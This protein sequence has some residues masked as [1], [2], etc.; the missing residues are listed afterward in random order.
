[1]TA[2]TSMVIDDESVAR[3]ILES[4]IGQLEGWSAPVPCRSALEAL[5]K[6]N[7]GMKPDVIF[8]DINMPVLSGIEFFR[9]LEEPPIAVFTTAYSEFAVDAFE[10]H[11]TDY[12]VKP[13]SFQRFLKTVQR[14]QSL[15]TP[16]KDLAISTT[17]KRDYM[18]VKHNGKMQRID[19]DDIIFIEAK[20]DY[21]YIETGQKHFMVLMPMKEIEE[22]VPA[23]TFRR[24]HRS[25]IV[26]IR[27][28]NSVHGNIIE[29]EG[30][31]IPIGVNYKEDFL[32][33][34]T[35]RNKE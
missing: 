25:F 20:G 34:I 11:V 9:L 27:K 18:F 26:N 15:L 22:Y 5:D 10:L 7:K 14:I 3:S 24:I 23:E 35:D 28:I 8:L 1:M 33:S 4:Y 30:K 32:K 6:I 21:I 19:L 31:E 13:I 17:I 29:M 2:L 16:E 12:L